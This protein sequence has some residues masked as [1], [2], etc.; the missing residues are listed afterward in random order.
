[1]YGASSKV[2]LAHTR[3][4]KSQELYAIY[5]PLL[6]TLSLQLLKNYASQTRYWQAVDFSALV[7]MVAAHVVLPTGKMF[8]RMMQ[9]DKLS[10]SKKFFSMCIGL[11]FLHLDN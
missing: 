11:V 5:Q 8:L 3:H 9:P 1:M 4:A 10:E 7:M 6:K 2:F